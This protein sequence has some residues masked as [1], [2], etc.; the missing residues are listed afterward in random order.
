MK[1]NHSW[2]TN[3]CCPSENSYVQIRCFSENEKTGDFLNTVLSKR[4]NPFLLIFTK[5]VTIIKVY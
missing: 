1:N 5:P 3:R 2:T 4:F